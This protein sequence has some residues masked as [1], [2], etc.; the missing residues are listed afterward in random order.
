MTDKELELKKGLLSNKQD[1]INRYQ[2]AIQKQIREEDQ[3]LTLTVINDYITDYGKSHGYRIIFGASGKRSIMFAGKE[4]DLTE[5][6]LRG[7]NKTIQCGIIALMVFVV[8][9]H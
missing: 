1:R 3:K 8:G 5:D 9:K 4:A 2:E 7:L 6:V